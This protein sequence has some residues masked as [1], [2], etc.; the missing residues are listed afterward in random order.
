MPREQYV[1]PLPPVSLILTCITFLFA[2][3]LPTA[4]RNLRP[5]TPSPFIGHSQ[6]R[7]PLAQKL[8]NS[9]AGLTC[10]DMDFRC[11]GINQI[12]SITHSAYENRKTDTARLSSVASLGGCASSADI[13]LSSY[14]KMWVFTYTQCLVSKWFNSN[15][16]L[17]LFF[18]MGLLYQPWRNIL[19]IKSYW[20]VSDK[21]CITVSGQA[22]Y[23][24]KKLM[25]AA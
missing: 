10:T 11:S 4:E 19:K 21:G 24:A 3:R 25:L 5:R 16:W 18:C 8:I 14:A 1:T 2:G 9:N 15:T 22:S 13:R 23:I 7:S 12:R 17:K 6:S 20:G